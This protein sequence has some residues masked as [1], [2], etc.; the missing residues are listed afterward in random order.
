MLCVGKVTQ[1]L[2]FNNNGK[3]K[4]SKLYCKT[5]GSSD[6]FYLYLLHPTAISHDIRGRTHFHR[7]LLVSQHTKLFLVCYFDLW[8][9]TSDPNLN[10]LL[11][12]MIWKITRI[13]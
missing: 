5:H 11:N 4:S 9:N 8:N 6:T 3:V 1:F 12:F 10:L 7:P 13:N 2:P